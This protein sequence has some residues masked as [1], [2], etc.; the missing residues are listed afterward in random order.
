MR[1]KLITSGAQASL[2]L[3]RLVIRFSLAQLG[4]SLGYNNA[5]SELLQCKDFN[6]L[7][8]VHIVPGGEGSNVNSIF[9]L[10]MAMHMFITSLFCPISHPTRT[11]LKKLFVHALMSFQTQAACLDCLHLQKKVRTMRTCVYVVANMLYIHNHQYHQ[12]YYNQ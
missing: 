5:L 6:F 2:L 10:S 1:L 11:A 12:A 8:E 3:L 9:Y 4:N 7:A